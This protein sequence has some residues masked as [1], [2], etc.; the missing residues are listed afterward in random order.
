[1]SRRDIYRGILILLASSEA[2]HAAGFA[3]KEQFTTAQ[4]TAFAGATASASD[5]SYMFFNPASLGWV[6]QIDIQA[7]GTLAMPKIRL[8]SSSAS[9]IFGTPISGRSQDDDVADNVFVPAFYAAVPLRAG[10]RLG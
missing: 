10:V 1:M 5:V 9:T 2:A 3:V 6:D 8:E 7:V 4:G